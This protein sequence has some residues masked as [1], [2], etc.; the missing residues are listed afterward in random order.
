MKNLLLII[1]LAIAGTTACVRHQHPF[2]H[3]E[4]IDL[5]HNYN[6]DAIYWPT[7][8]SYRFDTVFE[9]MTEKGYYYSSF[10]FSAEE[11]GGTHMDA[12]RHFSEGKK[13]IH[14]IKLSQM[15]GP[16]VVIDVSEKVLADRNYLVTTG[17]FQDWESK[18][19]RIPDQAMIMLNT[20]SAKYWPDREKYMGTAERG[21][22]AVPKLQ[23]P[24]LHPEAA[25]W[26]AEN[27]NINLVGLDTPSIDHGPSVYFEAH[28]NLFEHE[29]LVVENVTNLD[30]MPPSGA[31]IIALPMKI[32]HGSGAPVRIL[33]W[34]R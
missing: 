28:R 6:E 4:W 2:S 29:I 27:R 13:S 12:P 30:L 15:M 33:A 17:D 34:L 7:A 16:A 11:H 8:E 1:V 31:W 9:G 21:P 18:N 23:F 14:E 20:G 26:I 10:K 32:E 22:E 3:G 19:G 25:T 5:T 24:G